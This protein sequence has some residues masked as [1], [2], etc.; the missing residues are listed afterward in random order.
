MNCSI[1]YL[2]PEIQPLFVFG[3]VLS[4]ENQF[5]A[6]IFIS[7][8][9][10]THRI[11]RFHNLFRSQAYRLAYRPY[12][13]HRPGENGLGQPRLIFRSARPAWP[14][15]NAARRSPVVG[16]NSR[17]KFQVKVSKVHYSGAVGLD[18]HSLKGQGVE[19]GKLFS[20]A[21]TENTQRSLTR[22]GVGLAIKNH[23]RG[24]RGNSRSIDREVKRKLTNR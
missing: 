15:G 3:Y 4:G 17:P 12:R 19:N 21:L 10:D 9:F 2:A 8:G 5:L 23:G 24:S 14:I 16:R 7:L 13:P 18:T 1:F 22:Y 6:L 11:F 20:V